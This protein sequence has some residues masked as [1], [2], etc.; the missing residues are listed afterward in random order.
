MVP[1]NPDIE[2]RLDKVMV[3]AGLLPAEEARA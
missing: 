2:R 3:E 1:P